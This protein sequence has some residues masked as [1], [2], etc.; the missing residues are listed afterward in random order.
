[1]ISV[2]RS[3]VLLLAVG[4]FCLAGSVGAAETNVV[5]SHIVGFEY[6]RLAHFAGAQGVLEFRLR[7][8]PDGVVESAELVSG[9]GLLAEP[10][11]STLKRWRFSGCVAG[12]ECSFVISVHFVLSGGPVNISECKTD[13]VFDSPSRVTLRSQFARAIVD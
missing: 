3:R 12:N 13:F 8:R 6:P 5:A 9:N 7:I 10:T 1:M 4:M 11:S 2:A